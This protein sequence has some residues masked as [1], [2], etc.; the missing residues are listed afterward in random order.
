MSVVT[1]DLIKLIG[2]IWSSF[3][4]SFELE[5][6]ESLLLA[7][8]AAHWHSFLFNE[9]HFLRMNLL[10][11]QHH[12]RSSSRKVNN[13][14]E[15]EVLSLE[16]IIH[17]VYTLYFHQPSESKGFTA[18]ES[19][20]H[21]VAK[22]SRRES[23]VFSKQYLKRFTTLVFQR[24]LE[25]ESLPSSS[26]QA[27]NLEKEV[28]V[29]DDEDE[30]FAGNNQELVNLKVSRHEAYVSPMLML[31]SNIEKFTEEK[32]AENQG[33]LVQWLNK[34][35]LCENVKIRTLLFKVYQR[36]ISRKFV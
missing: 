3:L 22:Y 31:L 5:H 14:L 34:L 32:F 35:I 24:Y 29:D 26:V 11:H 12:Q 10:K 33:W 20:E 25:G 8:E 7:L 15:Q 16:C 23:E 21:A 36:H 27:L 2:Q 1:S 18:E 30:G 28:V 17:I 19:K 6:C 4:A 13:L 9:H